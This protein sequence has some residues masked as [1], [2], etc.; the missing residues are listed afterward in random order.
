VTGGGDAGYV[1]VAI[2]VAACGPSLGDQVVSGIADLDTTAGFPRGG[3]DDAKT[4]GS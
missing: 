3:A 4:V 2:E 1:E